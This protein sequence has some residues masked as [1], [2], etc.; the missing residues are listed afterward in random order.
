M[1]TQEGDWDVVQRSSEAMPNVAVP[2]FGVHPWFAH[3]AENGWIE[4]LRLRLASHPAALLGEIGL[5]KAA[6]TPETR[7]CEYEA[8]QEVFAAQLALAAELRRPVSVH[9]V[10]SVGKLFGMMEAG[11]AAAGL[12]P[13]I[14]LHS[15]GSSP[16]WI[17]R[18]L[19]LP[20]ELYVGF[21][22]AING[23]ENQREKLLENI[24]VV[25]DDRLL[26]ESDLECPLDI[27]EHLRAM[28]AIFAEAKGW[29]LEETAERTW[30][31]AERFV[32]AGG[33]GGV[34]AGRS[35][36]DCG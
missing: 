21:S 1:G 33:G 24:A 17:P 34:D 31:N 9:C 18:Y 7:R 26:L 28:C 27:E 32:A 23:R 30:A 13:A 8:Q 14:A 3:R 22:Y 36:T 11:A 20:T 12:P 5:D 29:S 16:D 25:P 19:A 4:R 35:A 15:Y 10:R 2:A 6:R